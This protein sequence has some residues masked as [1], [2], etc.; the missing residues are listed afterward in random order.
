MD[1]KTVNIETPRLLLRP[2]VTDDSK[3]LSEIGDDHRVAGSVL[4]IPVPFPE[5][6]ARDWINRGMTHPQTV[7]LAVLVTEDDVLAGSINLVLEPDHDQAEMGFWF[8]VTYWHR[9]YATEAAGALLSY[10]F[11]ELALN[12]VHAHHMLRNP[13]SGVVLHKI[14]MHAE[15][16]LRQRIKKNGVFEDVALYGI[17]REEFADVQK[18]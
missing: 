17:L 7:A 16:V 8:G 2:L 1:I 11:N 15:G 9:G 14:G 10:A 3:A 5:P 6:A 4:S 18:G 12:R 13:A